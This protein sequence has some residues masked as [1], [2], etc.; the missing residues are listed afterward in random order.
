MRHSAQHPPRLIMAFFRWFCNPRM[1]EDIEGDLLERFEIR[2]TTKGQFR[3]KI[4][5]IKDVLLLFRPSIIRSFK[6]SQK[7]NSYDM[8]RNYLK[9]AYRN[10]WIHKSHSAINISGLA[11][12]IAATLFMLLYVYYQTGFDKFH[13]DSD[14]IYRVGLH[15]KM[16]DSEFHQVYTTTQLAE[17]MKSDFPEVEEST[18]LRQV[19]NIT[20]RLF[21]DSVAIKS[22][23]ENKVFFADPSVF[24][25]FSM[26]TILGNGRDALDN[27]GKTVI[28][29]SSAIKYFGE[30][31][32]NKDILNKKVVASVGPSELALQVTAVVQDFPNQSHFH[33]NFLV[34]LKNTN[35]PENPSWWNNSYYTYIKLTPGASPDEVEAKL[36][37]LYKKHLPERAFEGGN[38]W[39]S[40]LQP[41]TDIHLKSNITGEFEPNGNITYVYIFL[42]TAMLILVMACVNFI[43][44]TI[45]KASGR[46]K[47]IGVRK[48]VGSNRRQLIFQHL[49]ESQMYCLLATTISSLILWLAMPYFKEFAQVQFNFSTSE[50][51]TMSASLLLFSLTIGTFAGLYPALYM[52]KLSAGTAVKGGQIASKRSL[53][54][55]GLI[56]FQFIISIGIITGSMIIS[57][58]LDFVQTKNLGFDKENILVLENAYLLNTSMETFKTEL[59]KNPEIT[60]TSVSYSIPTRQF[61]NVQFKPEDK[62]IMVLDFI[63]SDE[64]FLDTYQIEMKDGRF[65]STTFSNDSTSMVIN[66]ALAKNLGWENPIGKK[67]YLFGNQNLPY[68]IVGVMEDFHHLSLH[69]SLEP[70]AILP[71]FSPNTFGNYYVSMKVKGDNI[72]ETIARAEEVWSQFSPAPVSYFFLDDNYDDLYKGELQTKTIFGLFSGLTTFI[73][74]IGLL[75]LVANATQQRIKEISIRKVLGASVTQLIGLLSQRFLTILLVAFV[76]MAPLVWYM[77]NSWLNNFTYRIEV[78]WL[79]FV[80]SGSSALIISMIIIGVQSLK[81]V[82]LNPANTLRSE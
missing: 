8:F 30:D 45:A 55:S 31:W 29:E 14:R 73:A 44:L 75:G 10:L 19:G 5:F 77:M 56:T 66:E 12:G 74:I 49:V 46:F 28:T 57:Q 63:F 35:I 58:Q 41:L 7:L 53:F 78:P 27:P 71:S 39:W 13:R 36:P 54:R 62:K 64:D 18:R 38:E 70:L 32:R 16:Q 17:E 79:A 2:L 25:L 20:I 9:V 37:D 60:S 33:F 24:D 34:S 47:E 3:A 76:I 82:T 22:Y 50:L 48:V 51:I 1:A 43:N 72:Q 21:E 42:A 15:G 52:T 61:S 11:I 4:L 68:T 65:F 81:T 40:F 80:I 67:I 23:L 6:G 59:A 69:H 26:E